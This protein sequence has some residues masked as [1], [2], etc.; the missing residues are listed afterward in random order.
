M[1]NDRNFPFKW[2]AKELNNTEFITWTLNYLKRKNIILKE[3]LFSALPSINLANP[4]SVFIYHFVVHDQFGNPHITPQSIL[5][6]IQLT[7]L[8]IE[9]KNAWNV[10]KSR[11]KKNARIKKSRSYSLAPEAI[12]IIDRKAKEWRI[13]KSEALEKIV[14]EFDSGFQKIKQEF[15]EKN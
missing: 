12:S 1:E 13:S 14:I 7:H 2:T 4:D 5:N 6:Q 15:Q 9:M 10:K 3:N 8:G 11:T